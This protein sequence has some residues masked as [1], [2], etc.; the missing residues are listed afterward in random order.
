MTSK[1]KSPEVK[2][3]KGRTKDL[4]DWTRSAAGKRAKISGGHVKTI[5]EGQVVT[6][7]TYKVPRKLLYLNARNH[8]F[9]TEWD[10]LKTDRIRA[11]KLKSLM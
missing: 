4:A 8:R 7:E 6:R 5:F 9:T 2:T 10:N 11:K 1:R 3:D